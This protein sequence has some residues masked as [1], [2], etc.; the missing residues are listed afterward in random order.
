MMF[1]GSKVQKFKVFGLGLL[2]MTLNL[3][4]R[5]AHA[6]TGCNYPT[7]M[8]AYSDKQTGDFLTTGDVNSRSC[9]VEK[10][11]TGPLRPFSGTVSAPGYSFSGDTGTGMY[12]L[13]AGQIGFTAAGTATLNITSG[14]TLR[15]GNSATTG[16]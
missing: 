1:N 3:E 8:D 16:V 9:A 7:S 5:A 13:S 15:V 12:R 4:P 6:A 2:F 14:G 10:L 11:E